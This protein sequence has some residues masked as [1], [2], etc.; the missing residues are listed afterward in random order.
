M[1]ENSAYKSHN[2]TV[3]A[4]TTTSTSSDTL[5]NQVYIPSYHG[6]FSIEHTSSKKSNS[7]VFQYPYAT[8]STGTTI[9]SGSVVWV[10]FEGGDVRCPVIITNTKKTV[11][12][13]DYPGLKIDNVG[14]TEDAT[15]HTD[16]TFSGGGIVQK[17]AAE[18][19]LSH[20][21][22]GN[23]ATV[24]PNDN[25]ALSIGLIGWHGTNAQ[26]LMQRIKSNY[27][28]DWENNGGNNIVNL[29][30]DWS[31]KVLTENSTE[32]KAFQSILGSPGGKAV[33]DEMIL[34]YIASYID[35]A[36]GVG[37]TEASALV[38]FCDMAVQAPYGAKQIAQ[39][40]K[41]KDLDGLYFEAMNKEGYWLTTNTLNRNRRKDSYD[42][43]KQWIKDGK[44][45][46]DPS[47]VSDPNKPFIWPVPY[48]YS[49]ISSGY[50][51]RDIGSGTSFHKGIDISMDQ[52]KAKTND[53]AIIATASGTV[54]DAK[55]ICQHNYAKQSNCGC[56]GGAGRWVTIK[57]DEGGFVS[58]YLHL[59]NVYVKT[60]D[61]VDA[62][63]QIGTMGSTG[64]STG[65][66]LHF[67]IMINGDTSM[68]NQANTVNPTE[69]VGN[70]YLP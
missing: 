43:I 23:Y 56:G 2:F 18:L 54:I 42:R 15:V 63:Q 66:H 32:F 17:L 62:G 7:N 19:I 58:H 5:K 1:G 20:E 53:K 65:W 70:V 61:H 13:T 64:Y 16:A 59:C 14:G 39:N 51:Y 21:S 12:T 52:D 31:K 27:L 30:G 57:H 37:V 29:N 69:Y 50:G 40:A 68:N 9:G 11:K 8:N 26:T 28:Q 10:L 6:K 60:G 41:N 22:G 67:Q 48:S 3:K 55:S 4:I 24:V 47:G 35:I 49:Y 25:G 38:F 46:T 36:K 33:Q 34:E 45:S 44:F